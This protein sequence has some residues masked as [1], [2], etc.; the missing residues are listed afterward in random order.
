[1]APLPGSTR[2]RTT[3]L[4]SASSSASG[5][6]IPTQRSIQEVDPATGAGGGVTSGQ[7]AGQ[8]QAGQGQARPRRAEKRQAGRG[9][10]GRGEARQ[11]QSRQGQ[12]A[13]PLSAVGQPTVH[14]HDPHARKA[15]QA[16]AAAGS[17]SHLRET[18]LRAYDSPGD[19]A[20]QAEAAAGSPPGL[21]ETTVRTYGSSGD[22]LRQAEALAGPSWQVGETTTRVYGSY[23]DAVRQVQAA[24]REEQPVDALSWRL[25]EVVIDDG[26]TPCRR[27]I[28]TTRHGDGTVVAAAAGGGGG[29]A[30]PSSLRVY[31]ASGDYRVYTQEE[32]NVVLKLLDEGKNVY[33]VAKMTGVIIKTVQ[34]WQKWQREMQQGL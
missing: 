31:G 2:S 20:R 28:T 22:R 6:N 8:Q 9:E 18:T 5:S 7:G 10:A 13:L 11:G 29:G 19:R 25:G 30:S 34:K 4:T 33:Y 23:A 26:P 15:E 3:P 1:M 24:T 32:R 21:R 27:P 17:P 16:Q 12:A 14:G